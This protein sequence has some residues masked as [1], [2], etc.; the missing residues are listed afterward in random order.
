MASTRELWVILRGRDEAS[1]MVHS[2]ARNVRDASNA[3][4]AAQLQSQA[5]AIRQQAQLLRTNGAIAEQIRTINDHVIGLDKQARAHTLAAAQAREYRDQILRANGATNAQVASINQ[6]IKADTQRAAV[7]RAQAAMERNH[8][9]TLTTGLDDQVRA[10]NT[11]AAALDT[12]ARRLRDADREAANHARSLRHMSVAFQQASDVAMG[13]TFA[14]GAAAG[15]GA[16]FGFKAVQAAVAYEKQVRLTATQVDGFK[17]NL[18]E[19]GNVGIRVGNEIG[20]SFEQ[21]QPALFDIFSSMEVGVKDAEILLKA[22]AK[23]AV[24][25]QVEIQEVSRATIGLMNA[26]NRPVSDVN[27]LLDIQ[28]QL[29]Q[30]GV[31]TYA[32]WNQ[33]IGLV[34]PSAVRAGQSIETMAAALATAT[35]MGLSAARSGTSVARAMDAMSHPTAVKNM[36]ALGIQVRDAHGKMLPLNV[37]LRDFRDTLN[38]MPE[39][40]RLA[41]I[42]N[43]FK[44]AGGT[45]EARRFLQ[46][47]LLGKKNIELFD[48]VL[49]EMQ[50]TSGSMEK[51][52][53]TMADSV[54]VKTELLKN[55]WQILK[56]G[57]G[58]A[59]VPSVLQLVDA[60]S[61]ALDWFNRLP[62]STKNVIAQ[63]LLW[64]TAIAAAGAALFGIIAIIGFVV[65][66]FA[67]AGTAI[68]VVLGV[69]GAIATVALAVGAAFVLLWQKSENFRNLISKLADNAVAAKDV[70][71]DLAGKAADAFND[72]LGPALGDLWNTIDTKVI[73][74]IADL[75]D[76]FEEKLLPKLR[77]AGEVFITQ[78]KPAM[79]Q[80][81]SFIKNDLIPALEDL[82]ETYQ[83][84]KSYI[85]PFIEALGIAAIAIAVI[86]GVIVNSLIVPLRLL[87]F[88]FEMSAKAIGAIVEHFQKLDN[89]AKTVAGA[90]VTAGDAVSNFFSSVISAVG[91]FIESVVA[92]FD[93]LPGRVSSAIQS[94]PE[95]VGNVWQ[96]TVDRVFYLVGFMTSKVVQLL[97]AWVGMIL[98]AIIGI[99]PAIGRVFSTAYNTATDWTSRIIVAVITLIVTL[100]NRVYNAIHGIIGA[101]SRVFSSATSSAGS[102]AQN[103]LNRIMSVIN[104]IGPRVRST[105]NTLPGIIASALANAA[106]R[107]FAGGQAIVRSVVG[108]V[109]GLIGWAAGQLRRAAASIVKGFLDALPG[110]PVKWG[111]L[112]V[113]NNGKMGKKIVRMLIDGMEGEAVSMRNAFQGLMSPNPL[114]RP[115]TPSGYTPPD[116]PS[117]S[118]SGTS[119]GGKVINNRINITTQEIDPRKHAADLGWE[120][121]GRM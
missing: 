4:R 24:A 89:A 11:H 111:P 44:G 102:G 86:G 115:T 74:V 96:R 37:V 105:F 60:L 90:I 29:V 117:S 7:L 3:V 99:P 50:N 30:E 15:A 2:F 69:L 42:L 91:A 40:D 12:E 9:A 100:P 48:A 118:P 98:A 108:G 79:D 113:L 68:V 33:R 59:L 72:K 88:S 93:Q 78:I 120:L 103:V 73:P 22:F 26:F 17:G 53:S 62:D 27:K 95:V 80:A 63:F 28:F 52:Y 39:K 101:I 87:G 121:A 47:M 16:I 77:E 106:G 65:A 84:N 10:L 70:L 19:L 36:E 25:G 104:Q 51:A 92:F 58:E 41:A 8:I 18:E 109:T 20:V 116:D 38:K 110:S 94:L 46:N 49:A 97:F 81:A 82:A 85:D 1:R 23:G 112:K 114:L 107:A 6:A 66:A 119:S 14:L 45:I 34:T 13:L 32:E 35:R 31:G 75:A 43:V 57:I 71:V 67:T 5:A 56:I 54:A 21:V 76:K 55:K 83:E 64:G 61:K